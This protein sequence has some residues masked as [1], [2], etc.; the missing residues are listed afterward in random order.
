[1]ITLIKNQKNQLLR[2][3]DIVFI[4]I[5]MAGLLFISPHIISGDGISR[6][7]AISRLLTRGELSET[8]YSMVGSIFSIPL[9]FLGTF[10]KT[11]E[12]WVSKYN[13]ILFAIGLLL[14]YRILVNNIDN[15]MLRK[16]LLILIFASMIPHHQMEYYGE[17]FSVVLVGVGLLAIN[18]G[19]PLMGWVSIILG[20]I[21]TPASVIG[22]G[23]VVC[24]EMLK[25]KKLRYIV[26]LVVTIGLILSE[27]WIRRGGPFITGY[28]DNAGFPTILPYSGRPG[29]SYPIFLGLIS[30]LFSFG[31]GIIWFSP[32]IL[33][34]VKRNMNNV[35]DKVYGSYQLWIYFSIGL[36]LVYSMWWSWYGGWF[37]GP[38]FFLF[39]SLPASLALTVNLYSKRISIVSNLILFVVLTWSFWVGINGLIFGN[40]NLEI[41][42]NKKYALEALCW[43]VPEFSV[44]FRPF[45]VLKQLG[46]ADVAFI[47]LYMMVFFYIAMPV[48]YK[49]TSSI[50]QQG[51][52]VNTSYF[53]IGKW[54]I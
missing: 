6:F 44:L 13:Y 42:L 47:I 23:F 51:K 45:V 32:G 20:V 54:G 5:G 10:Y 14:I 31:K 46:K 41:C 22:L 35:T 43:Y 3:F 52:V 7:E 40:R 9:F 29:F 49:L 4:L 26:V 50:I 25:R 34:P 2:F 21:N 48:L 11:P 38:R 18:Y 27:S 28:E 19:Y 15:G 53:N 12:W 37:W 33:L 36:V 30:V 1:M 17:I 39:A 8:P 16:F 24:A